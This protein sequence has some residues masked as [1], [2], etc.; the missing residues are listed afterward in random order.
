MRRKNAGSEAPELAEVVAFSDRTIAAPPG[1]RAARGL[2]RTDERLLLALTRDGRR[3]AAA[4]AKDLGLSRQA[5]TER[6]RELERRGVI[7]GYLAD[8]DPAALGLGVRAHLRLTL[9]NT[10][11]AGREKE[12]FRVL[13]SSPFVRSLHR[14]SGEDCLMAQV[15][16]RQI[17]DVSDLLR[18][19]QATRALQS[20]RTAFV[21]EVVLDKGA[22]GS[23]DAL[24]GGA[25]GS[26]A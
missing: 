10:A 17:E 25:A 21:L 7:R 16:A 3:S 26:R 13:S 19:L 5:V 4:L 22:L 12:V 8:V 9:D 24:L 1:G 15:V 6:I 18:Q 2:D 11:A 20:S 23:V 14:V